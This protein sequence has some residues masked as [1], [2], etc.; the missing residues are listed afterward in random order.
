MELSWSSFILEIINFLV[1]VWILKHFFYAP[2]QKAIAQRQKA[3]EDTIANSTRLREEAGQLQ[4]RYENRLKDWE[5]EKAQ[6]QKEFRQEMEEWKSHELAGFQKSLE[7]EREKAYSQEK[8]R[9]SSL[10]ENNARE[11]MAIAAGFAARF[12]TGF[13]DA[14]LENKIIARVID[15][16]SRTKDDKLLSL[17]N[18]P[19][20]PD[21]VIQSAYV[22]GEAQKKKLEETLKQ[23]LGEKIGIRFSQEPALLAGLSI[24]ID[25]VYI[26]A[27]LRDELAYFAD[28]EKEHA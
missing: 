16:L 1:L 5:T 13:A 19:N 28:V 2:I 18:R 21:V 24:T 10:M 23:I 26:Q 22:L 8:Q 12:L 6:K 3:V 14:G 20:P 27:N 7:K 11:S 9:I 15:D 25:S 17:K 4:A